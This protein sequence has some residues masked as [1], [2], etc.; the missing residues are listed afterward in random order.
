MKEW[1]KAWIESKQPR[2]QRKYRHKAPLHVRHKFVSAHLSPDL[3]K[4]FSRRS[5][6]IRKGDGV[7][8]TTGKFKG[9]RG[10][11]TRVDLSRCMVYVEGTN[12]KKVDGS[13]LARSIDP[14]NLIITKLNLDDKRRKMAIDRA[15]M[16]AE[17]AKEK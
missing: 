4:Q 15:P 11:V 2:K 6:P 16:K 10:D 1:S 3:R 12:I 13:E 7:M 8:I 14:S 9:M 17:T 5:F